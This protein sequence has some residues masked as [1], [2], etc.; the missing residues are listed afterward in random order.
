MA[1]QY[2][3]PTDMTEEEAA[4]GFQLVESPI[5]V[6]ALVLPVAAGLQAIK[7]RLADGSI[8]YTVCDENC[9]PLYRGARTIAELKI[10]F[11]AK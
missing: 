2:T 11:G 10:R 3:Y 6:R 9:H 5:G 4:I 7:L 1:A 8:E